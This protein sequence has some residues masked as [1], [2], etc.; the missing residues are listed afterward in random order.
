[1]NPF[2]G[3]L[4]CGR[5]ARRSISIPLAPYRDACH[6]AR[7]ALEVAELIRAFRKL[8]PA[9]RA[10]ILKLSRRLVEWHN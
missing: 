7:D 5:S 4:E 3:S 6:E 9:D 8:D 10:H 2:Q 1:M